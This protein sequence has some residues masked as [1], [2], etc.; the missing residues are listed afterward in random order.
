[1]ASQTSN[2]PQGFPQIT[3]PLVD[4]RGYASQPWYQLFITLWNR[5]GGGS[6]GAT[7]QTGTLLAFSTA[8]LPS[9]YLLCDGAAVSRT[10]F[11]TLFAIIGTTWGSGDGSTT[12]NVPD[13]R[14]RFLYGSGTNNV[15]GTGGNEQ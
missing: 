9:G 15:G 11:T 12:F 3:A 4:Q 10:T 7:V 6:G 8:T 14:N 5:T 1:M 13:L 2:Q